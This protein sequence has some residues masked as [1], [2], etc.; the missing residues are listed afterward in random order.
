MMQGAKLLKYLGYS[1]I[2]DYAFGIFLV[3]WIV[4]RH[5]LYN[6][7]MYSVYSDSVRIITPGCYVG[8]KLVPG[9]EVTAKTLLDTFT[10]Q[11]DIVCY[12]LP[13]QRTFVGMLVILQIITL[14]WLYMILRVAWK[15]LSGGG[16]DD[17]RSED[18]DEGEDENEGEDEKNEVDIPEEKE[19]VKNGSARPLLNGYSLNHLPELG[20]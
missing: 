7:I 17:T 3:G 20:K 2:C 16:A 5:G 14:V 15:V 19:K 18:E 11:N 13:V 8:G 12:S 9:I 6:W 10:F 1:T 4:G